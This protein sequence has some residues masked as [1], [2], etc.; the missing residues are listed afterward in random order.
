MNKWKLKIQELID[1]FPDADYIE[2]LEEMID[3]ATTA[4]DARIEELEEEE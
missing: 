3:L 4:R 2:L 1:E